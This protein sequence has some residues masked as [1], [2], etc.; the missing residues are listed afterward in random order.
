MAVGIVGGVKKTLKISGQDIVEG[1]VQD[2][3]QKHDPIHLD[4]VLNYTKTPNLSNFS[5]GSIRDVVFSNDGAYLA[6]AHSSAPY[7]SIYKNMGSFYAKL[8]NP[9]GLPLTS[10]RTVSFTPQGNHLVVGCN[11]DSTK[12]NIHCYKRVNDTFEK[13]KSWYIQNG[14]DE[15]V[16]DSSGTYLAIRAHAD[17][18]VKILRRNGNSLESIAFS[19]YPESSVL[20]VSFSWSANLL[21]VVSEAEISLYTRS[22]DSFSKTKVIPNDYGTRDASISGDGKY[23]AIL[24]PTEISKAI[25]FKNTSAGFQR[26]KTPDSI[27]PSDPSSYPRSILFTSNQAYVSVSLDGYPYVALYKRDNDDFKQEI[28]ENLSPQPY[29]YKTAFDNNMNLAIGSFREPYL[30]LY[31]AES[32]MGVYKFTSINS[33]GGALGMGY[34]NSNGDLGDIIKVTRLFR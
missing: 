33:Q 28:I 23:V 30:A 12:D 21:L 16:W 14:P 18:K 10:A 32:K 8:S 31:E 29:A 6:V 25:F 3:V 11:A 19:L 13:T 22:G 7:I 15:V 9:R 27:I 34:A 4:T 24:A 5:G 20:S 2:R 17:P 1:E 26:L